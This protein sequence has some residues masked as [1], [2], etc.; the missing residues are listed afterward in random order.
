[1]WRL[2]AFILGLVVLVGVAVFVLE[3]TPPNVVACFSGTPA[4]NGELHTDLAVDPRIK[5]MEFTLV[6]HQI[7]GGAVRWFVTDPIGNTKWSGREE[8]T[9]TYRSG[10]IAASSGIWRVNLISEAD[11]LDYALEWTGATAGMNSQT[12]PSPCLGGNV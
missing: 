8:A 11:Q 4:R 6:I 7:N 3:S 12:L 1:M 9:G 10:S 2:V 5:S